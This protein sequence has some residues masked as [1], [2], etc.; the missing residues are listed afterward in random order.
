[1][2]CLTEKILQKYVE[3]CPAFKG[4]FFYSNARKTISH[5][6]VRSKSNT[7]R[8]ED[9]GVVRDVVLLTDVYRKTI[10]I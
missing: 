7:I 4:G 9:D 5:L 10:K 3:R 8:Y 2:V 6:S 1:M